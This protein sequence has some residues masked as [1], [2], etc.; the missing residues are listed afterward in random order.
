MSIPLPV[1]TITI[2]RP[3]N[4]ADGAPDDQDAWSDPWEDPES[5]KVVATGIPANI[6]KILV[7]KF[8]DFRDGANFPEM[9]VA[10]SADPCDLR[11]DDWVDDELTGLTYRVR[12]CVARQSTFAPMLD[13]TIGDLERVDGMTP[14]PH[15]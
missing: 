4:Y 11:K 3:N 12:W 15:S 5:T 1:T 8:R 14:G 9:A 2:R 7:S 6:G 10:L 13:R